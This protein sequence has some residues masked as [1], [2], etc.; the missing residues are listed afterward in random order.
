M[1]VLLPP[2]E[3][4]RVGGDGSPLRLPDLGWPECSAL[5]AD[6]VSELVDLA[7]DPR[8]AGGRWG[9]PRPRTPRSN[10]THPCV[11]SPTLPAISR[12]TGVLYDALDVGSLRGAAATCAYARLA[13]GSALFGLLRAGDH[14]PAYRLSASSKLPGRPGLA[15]AGDRFSNLCWPNWPAAISWSICAQRPTSASVGSVTRSVST[16]SP[17][18]PTG[19]E[20]RSPISTR[21]IKAGWPGAG[22]A[23]TSEPDDAAAVAA[24]AG[25]A[26]MRVEQDGNHLTVMVDP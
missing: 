25:R 22:H 20:Q 12:Y 1:I 24:V 16:S 23:S 26:G 18:I 10:A 13:I 21:R 9:S 4:K 6:L 5:R 7:S 17:S 3:T 2:S 11:K 19:G 14:I 15:P 8:R